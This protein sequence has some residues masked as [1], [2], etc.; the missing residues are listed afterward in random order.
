MARPEALVLAHRGLISLGGPELRP[1]LQGLVSNDVEKVSPAK[2]LWAALLTPQGKFLHEFIMAEFEGALL[3]DCEAER[4]GDLLLRL[5][6][7]RLRAKVELA[8]ASDAFLVAACYGPGAL[9]ALELPPE[10]GHCRAF[11][12]GLAL[13]DPRRAELGARLILPRATAEEIFGR[14]FASGSLAAYDKLRMSQGVPD[15]SRDLEVER[16]ILL[17]NGFDE[18]GGV[19][20]GKGCFIG[21][22]LTA[23]TKHRA[24]IK[25]RLIPVAIE[26]L[27]PE[28]DS[29]VR[30][31]G[32]PAGSLRSHS[33]NLGLALLR[34]ERL[35][36]AGT[37][38]AGNAALLPQK[39][40]WA[41]F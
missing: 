30:K 34:L 14:Y 2:S 18:L 27:L 29:E 3:L 13:V 17:E 33:G 38:T 39:P 36:E 31:N 15:G 25:K 32:K 28:D 37:L 19:D 12:G 40:D 8:D 10:P 5:K 4:R 7:Y 22:E 16:S 41:N 23:R 20:W 35:G 9:E 26:G 6:R 1:F 21:Q 24:L 11:E